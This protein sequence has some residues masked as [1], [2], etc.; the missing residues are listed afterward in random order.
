MARGYEEGK[1]QGS[2][3]EDESH[4]QQHH[5]HAA[6]GNN[7]RLRELALK[8]VG[9]EFAPGRRPHG[10]PDMMRT[11]D[12]SPSWRDRRPTSMTL[13]RGGDGMQM[14]S[15]SPREIEQMRAVL[16]R[17]LTNLG[18]ALS[19]AVSRYQS[20]LFERSQQKIIK[21]NE[22]DLLKEKLFEVANKKILS[23]VENLSEA[24]KIKS[25]I[26]KQIDANEARAN[27]ETS[28]DIFKN[29]NANILN[30]TKSAENI[31]TAA[32]DDRVRQ[33]FEY[34]SAQTEVLSESTIDGW[35][36]YLDSVM[37]ATLLDTRAITNRE[38]SER[39]ELR[40]HL[41]PELDRARALFP[42]KASQ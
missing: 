28:G 31:V 26:S 27:L 33:M 40:R 23:L 7:E 18:Q 1:V 8:R 2:T 9:Q 19:V 15:Y 21:K 39:I 20:I 4:H 14:Q 34:S 10:R 24:D 32:S 5:H 17:K 6:H 16:L 22:S 25:A 11:H 35:V 12:G 42:W 29:A 13:E 30:V 3:W 37:T 38:W 36:R 41:Q